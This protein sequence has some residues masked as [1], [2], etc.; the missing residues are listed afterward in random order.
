MRGRFMVSDTLGHP[1]AKRSEFGSPAAPWKGTLGLPAPKCRW[2]SK[3][4]S[5][6]G[7]EGHFGPQVALT[8]APRKVSLWGFVPKAP[9]VFKICLRQPQSAGGARNLVRLWHQEGHFGH[10]APKRRW[11]SEFGPPAAP[12][13]GTS[14]LL[15]PKGRR[16]STFGPPAAPRKDT[17]GPS[18]PKGPAVSEHGD[19]SDTR[20][21]PASTATLYQ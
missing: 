3:F 2:C 20:S 12:R 8:S 4:G 13:K 6:C 5:A 19:S 16:S 15:V 18:G 7:A 17:F 10:S 9:V 14:R 11:H 1:A 21:V